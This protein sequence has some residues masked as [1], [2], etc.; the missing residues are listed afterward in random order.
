M[1]LSSPFKVVQG[2]RLN[3]AGH[4]IVGTGMELEHC[5]PE[6]CVRRCPAVM[7]LTIRQLSIFIVLLV[8]Q[9]SSSSILYSLTC[10]FYSKEV[11][12]VCS[13]KHFYFLLLPFDL[14]LFLFWFGFLPQSTHFKLL[15][16]IK[17]LCGCWI[18]CHA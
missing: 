8:S 15:A 7:Y 12:L 16:Y 13:I 1:C 3:G 6:V 4:C 10:N 11:T 2:G 14:G 9:F 17:F 5:P 18:L